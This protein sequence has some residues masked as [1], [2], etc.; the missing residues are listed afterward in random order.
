MKVSVTHE[1]DLKS[2]VA[3]LV[4]MLQEAGFEESFSESE[5][6]TGIQGVSCSVRCLPHSYQRRGPKMLNGTIFVPVD[7]DYD[8][9]GALPQPQRKKAMGTRLNDKVRQ[10]LARLPLPATFDAVRFLGEHKAFLRRRGW[11]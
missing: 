8:E 4:G 11:L 9:L 5:Y 2:G 1:T 10:A 3:D 6:G 7:L